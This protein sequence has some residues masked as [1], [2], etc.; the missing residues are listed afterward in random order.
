M[1]PPTYERS[2]ISLEC[3][4]TMTHACNGCGCLCHGDPLKNVS[5]RERSTAQQWLYKY[6]RD[7]E[8]KLGI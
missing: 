5:E 8:E 7:L 2:R 4:V 3:S 1:N 6:C